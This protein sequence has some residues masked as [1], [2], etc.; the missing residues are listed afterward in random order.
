[1]EPNNPVLTGPTSVL[2]GSIS[3]W[4]CTTSGGRPAPT[5][6]IRIGNSK[7]INGVTQTSVQQPDNTYIVTSV[8]SWAPTTDNQDKTLYCD[9]QHHNTQGNNIRT[10]SLLLNIIGNNSFYISINGL[11]LNLSCHHSY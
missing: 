2:L 10:A 9:V 8:L 5:M 3:E 7:I 6:S 11:N 4:T 1:M